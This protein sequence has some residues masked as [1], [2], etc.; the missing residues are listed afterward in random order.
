MHA[1]IR[2]DKLNY[3]STYQIEFEGYTVKLVL[4]D[5]KNLLLS[6]NNNIC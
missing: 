1:P 5:T 4:Y 6:S 3:D 2:M